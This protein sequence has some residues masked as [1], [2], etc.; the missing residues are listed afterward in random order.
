MS[1]VGPKVYRVTHKQSI[2]QA[3]FFPFTLSLSGPFK[4]SLVLNAT[5]F[6]NV[7]KIK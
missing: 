1:V 3:V 6:K 2:T 7:K 5:P 4:A